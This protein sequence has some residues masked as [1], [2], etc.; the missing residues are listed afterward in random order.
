MIY[1]R[2]IISTLPAEQKFNYRLP[3]GCMDLKFVGKVGHTPGSARFAL[4]EELLILADFL[5]FE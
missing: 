5:G 4:G 2:A 3:Y 1:I